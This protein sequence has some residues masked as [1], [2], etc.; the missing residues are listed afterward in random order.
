[1]YRANQHPR[2]P[3]GG[4]MSQYLD[5]MPVGA[6]MD[7]D[8]PLGHITYEEPGVI[9]SLGEDIRVKHFVAVAGG[10]GITPVVQVLRAVLSN[11]SDDAKFSLVFAARTPEDL[12]LREELDALAKQ[13]SQFDVSNDGDRWVDMW[14][15]VY[16]CICI[17]IDHHLTSSKLIITRHTK[18][19]RPQVWYTVDIAPADWTYSVGFINEA[20]LSGRFPKA[21][22]D[23]GVLICGPPPMINFAVKPA[24]NAMGYV[25]DQFFIF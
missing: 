5:R 18:P 11:P 13:H 17:C 15:H 14:M 16:V 3:A 2:F 7:I 23:V 21:S 12:L 19:Q 1:M 8:G 22:R 20:M 10:T 4:V 6:C 25:E 24:L 9:R